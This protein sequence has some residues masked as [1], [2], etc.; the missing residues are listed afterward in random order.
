MSLSRKFFFRN[1]SQLISKSAY[2]QWFS[3]KLPFNRIWFIQNYAN[4]ANNF[5]MHSEKYGYEFA[6]TLLSSVCCEIEWKIIEFT[7]VRPNRCRWKIDKVT[8][9]YSQTFIKR[10]DTYSLNK[11]AWI[12]KMLRQEETSTDSTMN[13]SKKKNI[14]DINCLIALCI[15]CLLRRRVEINGK[16]IS[17]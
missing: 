6:W 16:R 10:L 15:H 3:K 4:C 1:G 9:R 2:R 7:I 13:R 17:Y 14:N 5:R 8:K 11:W 12:N